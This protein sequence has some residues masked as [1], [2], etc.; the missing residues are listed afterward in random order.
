MKLTSQ[1]YSSHSFHPS[2][3]HQTVCRC[4]PPP[5][6]HPQSLSAGRVQILLLSLPPSPSSPPV[7]CGSG[8]DLWLPGLAGHL[9]ATLRDDQRA[10]RGLTV[11]AEAADHV[12]QSRAFRLPLLQRESERKGNN[13]ISVIWV[14][15]KAQMSLHSLRV[16]LLPAH[17]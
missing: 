3:R 16:V 17:K 9:G 1:K 15:Q 11:Q 5:L 10:R 14:L 4:D 7:R 8:D 6:P 12:L 13:F 2:A